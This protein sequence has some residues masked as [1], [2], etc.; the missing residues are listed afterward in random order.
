[1]SKKNKTECFKMRCTKVFLR[2]LLAICHTKGLSMTD[3][4][5][6]L[7]MSEYNKNPEYSEKYYEDLGNEN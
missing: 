7:V 2:K 3:V 1:M 4:I 5:E 6:D